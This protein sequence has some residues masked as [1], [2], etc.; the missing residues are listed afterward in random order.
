MRR[1]I[2]AIIM[3]IVLLSSSLVAL[4]LTAQSKD[5]AD[6]FTLKVTPDCGFNMLEWTP[7][8]GASS[9]W[10]YRGP[11]PG[12]EYPTPLTDF[13]IPDT[14]FKDD[15][16]IENGKEYCYYLTG[17]NQKAEEFGRS[18]EAC[19]TPKCSGEEEPVPPEEE[20]CKLVLKYQIENKNYYKNGAQLGPMETAPEIQFNRMFLLIRYVAQEVG[21]LV[22]W[23]AAQKRVIIK[24]IDGNTIEIWVGKPKAKVNG[25]EKAIDPNN[26]KVVGY[27]KGGR[28]LMPMRFVA[29]NLGATGPED[30]K[31][32]EATKTV[33]LYFGD[34]ECRK[35]VCLTVVKVDCNAKPP[36][37]YCTD[38]KGRNWTVYIS[39]EMCRQLKVGGCYSFCG[40]VRKPNT[41]PTTATAI[42]PIYMWASVL[43]PASCPCPDDAPPETDAKCVCITIEKNECGANGNM[44]SGI[45]DDGNI[46]FLEVTA[47]QCA[48]MIPGSCWKVCGSIVRRINDKTVLMKVL[49]AEK[50]ECPC[51][52]RNEIVKEKKDCRCFTV[53]RIDCNAA[54]P[55]VYA[56]DEKGTLWQLFVTPEQCRK[57]VIG[58][59]YKACGMVPV[60]IRVGS[61]PY[62]KVETFEETTC[63]CKTDDCEWILGEILGFG[64]VTTGSAVLYTVQ[65]RKCGTQTIIN[66]TIKEDMLDASGRQRISEY[67]GCAKICVKEGV[68]IKWER[69]INVQECCASIDCDWVLGEFTTTWNYQ[70][71]TISFKPCGKD[72]I[73]LKSDTDMQD[74]TK[75]FPLSQYRGCAKVCIKDGVIIKWIALWDQKPCCPEEKQTCICATIDEVALT[76]GYIMVTDENGK[77]WKVLVPAGIIATMKKGECWKICGQ[78]VTPSAVTFAPMPTLKGETFNKTDCPCKPG[79]TTD[80]KCVCLTVQKINCDSNNPT[81]QGIDENGNQWVFVV[82]PEICKKLLALFREKGE[83]LCIKIC[84]VPIPGTNLWKM[85]RY[86]MVDCPCSTPVEKICRCVKIK[87][88]DCNSEPPKVYGTD[89]NGN[90]IVLVLTKEQCAKYANYLVPEKCI[91]V[92]GVWVKIALGPNI[93]GLGLKI[94]TIEPVDCERCKPQLEEKC[95]CLTVMRISCD[96]DPPTVYGVDE[97]GTPFTFTVPA[98]VCSKLQAL[99]KEKGGKLCIKI[100]GV[101]VPGTNIWKMT[102]F[103]VVDCPCKPPEPPIECHCIKILKVDCEADPP[104]VYGTDENG[105]GITLVLEKWMCERYANFLVPEKCI[106]VCGTWVTLSTSATA[107]IK[108]F[109]VGTLAPIDCA[110]CK[111]QQE[112]KCVCLT[113]KRINCDSDQ[114]T[115]LG[116]DEN[117]IEYTFVINQEYC[118]KLAELWQKTGG[119]V[120]VKICGVRIPGTNLWKMTKLEFVDCPCKPQEPKIDCYCVKILKVDCTSDPPKVYVKDENGNEM[121]LVLEKWMCE[122]YAN[123]LVPEK[124]LKVCGTWI[125]IPVNESTTALGFKVTSVA[126][127]ECSE[128]K[129]QEPVEKCVC[130]TIQKFNCDSDQPTIY[131]VDENGVPYAFVVPADYCKRIAEL[132]QKTNGKVCVK[133]C[134]VKIPGTTLW[135]MTKLEFVDCPCKTPPSDENCFC[136]TLERFEESRGGVYIIG[137]ADTGAPTKL[138]LKKE[139]WDKYREILKIGGCYKICLD[140]TGAGNYTITPTECPCKPPAPKDECHCVTI[141][142]VDCTS[143]PPKVYG[144]DEN[145]N[146][147]T[148]VLEKW[149]CEK[150]GNFLVPEHCIKVCG[151]WT[152]S[153]SAVANI[154]MFKV[155]SLEPTECPCKP[156]EQ[157]TDCEW[158]RVSIMSINNDPWVQTTYGSP[159]LVW[160]WLCGYSGITNT[161]P[162]IG[163]IKAD[164]ADLMLVAYRGC[165]EICIK[166]G[167]IVKWRAFPNDTV[168]CTGPQRTGRCVT[169]T[170]QACS[171]NPP[172]VYGTTNWNELIKLTFA[173]AADCARFV[174]KSCWWVNGIIGGGGTGYN[175][176]LQV[177][178]FSVSNE[179]PCKVAQQTT[180]P[181]ITL[182]RVDCNQSIKVAWGK[183]ATGQEWMLNLGGY[184][185]ANLRPGMCIIATG[186]AGGFNKLRAMDVLSIQI[187]NCPC[188][189]QPAEEKCFCVTIE[190]IDCEAKPPVAYARDK[191]NVLW[192]IQITAEACKLMQ[193]GTCWEICGIPIEQ[194]SRIPSLRLTKFKQTDCPC[195]KPEGEMGEIC[196]TILRQNCD[197]SPPYIV[198]QDE[199]GDIWQISVSPDLCAKFKIGTC[200]ILYGRKIVDPNGVVMSMIKVEKFTQTDCPCKKTEELKCMCVEIVRVNCDA[201]PPTVYAKTPEGVMWILQVPMDYCK[202]MMIGS[203]WE[204]CGYEI[205]KTAANAPTMSVKKAREVEC[206]CG[207]KPVIQCICITI[208]RQDCNSNPPKVYGKEANGRMWVLEVPPDLCKKMLPG[209]C[210]NVC[211]PVTKSAAADMPIMKVEKF[212]QV[213][214]PC[215]GQTPEEPCFCVEVVDVVCTANGGRVYAKDSKGNMWVLYVGPDICQKIK[216]KTCWKVCG[217]KGESENGIPTLKVTKIEQTTCPCDGGGQG[218][219]SGKCVCF[220]VVRQVCDTNNPYVVYIDEDGNRGIFYTSSLGGKEMCEKMKVGTCWIK[221]QYTD[222]SGM[223]VLTVSPDPN[224][225]C[226]EPQLDCFCVEVIK[227]DCDPTKPPVIVVKNSKGSIFEI[228]LPADLAEYCQKMTVGTCWK[229]CGRMMTMADG[230]MKFLVTTID[231]ANCPCEPEV[232]ECKPVR[233]KIVM[234]KYVDDQLWVTFQSCDGASYSYFSI[235]DLL[236]TT[237]V[238]PLSQYTGCAVICV[239]PDGSIAYWKALPNEECC[240]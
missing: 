100:C 189:G 6:T 71:K 120:C 109:K 197:F 191:N 136:F 81:V 193:P 63:P 214:C 36:T 18:N 55:T 64:K 111:P 204:V 40:Y 121:M 168:C 124:C 221:C 112:E 80:E 210:W 215:G 31:W 188:A 126:P 206:P 41:T 113:V 140:P 182:D 115:V 222:A 12:Q 90:D 174:E 186:Y 96:T 171:E 47:D 198:G 205:N 102:K 231:Q 232:Q 212:D 35:C 161:M 180:T 91:K 145:G 116:V 29:E 46:Y 223:V 192:M 164:N 9:Y 195:A 75:R 19:A 158:K 200:W 238:Y 66:Y 4:P 219:P 199:N 59:C 153:V 162:A 213:K 146:P 134:G 3:S 28:V 122:R 229:I 79:G 207:E 110:E 106:K 177:E 181:C 37:A 172:A 89:E 60:L 190:K 92:C 178:S 94:E 209:T 76:A 235:K 166:D 143:D 142:K 127:I 23:D 48:Q 27:I 88:V 14:K 95:V 139:I 86:E 20:D 24:T 104:K 196:V 69:I 163:D 43:K 150:Y 78:D 44:V 26:P 211:G 84:G 21:A 10:I 52:P 74:E 11:G 67:K 185:C 114:P 225:S 82:S 49:R 38:K 227:S 70:T 151:V 230:V 239:N 22:E 147:I 15:I 129:P 135:K 233:G 56:K 201:T 156:T 149:M 240:P 154:K 2:L 184:P 65:F 165:A 85:A 83:K 144:K 50:T 8:P 208:E 118:K 17:V 61:M 62:M 216:P 119:K 138:F 105:N 97:N 132:W 152:G 33:E 236:D 68:I 99:Y 187:T 234:T 176:S 30:I 45:G 54:K 16:N 32:F 226:K 167:K 101:R 141:L 169:V 228:N 170:R 77:K 179:C 157:P 194:N 72:V 108:G 133:I 58:K 203:C 13:P 117:G 183:D 123:F 73:T 137:K 131:G 98:D 128:C 217:T 237:G 202:N 159:V 220:K 93:D 42:Q 5:I 175:V 39:A 51:K 224:C 107:V 103:E 25:V 148:L 34:P 7:L 155:T 125:K 1:A 160:Y 173:N 218:E 87:R 57:F 53:E 130:L